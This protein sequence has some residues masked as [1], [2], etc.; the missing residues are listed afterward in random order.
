MY[1]VDTSV[2]VNG[3]DTHETGHERCKNFAGKP[4]LHV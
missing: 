3:S 1:T 2:W 4:S